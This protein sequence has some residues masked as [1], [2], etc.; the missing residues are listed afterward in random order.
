MVYSSIIIDMGRT[1]ASNLIQIREFGQ[2][3]IQAIGTGTGNGTIEV[4]N[5]GVDWIENDPTTTNIDLTIPIV[6]DSFPWEFIRFV[7]I[8]TGTDDL[9][10]LISIKQ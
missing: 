7:P 2:M 10:M 9:T 5:N 3:A 1:D 4:S 6:L 8:G